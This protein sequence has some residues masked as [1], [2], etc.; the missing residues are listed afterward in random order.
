MVAA[1]T[2]NEQAVLDFFETLSS[3]DLAVLASQLHEDMSWEP[4]VRDIPGA[5]LHQGRDKV[6][7]EFLAPVRGA[8]RPG[9]PKVSVDAMVS[10]GD[11]V[12][13][14]T[15]ATG[16]KADDGRPYSN[17]Y[18]WAFE[19]RDG[20]ILRVRE[21]MDSLYVARFWGMVPDGPGA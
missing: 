1:K 20:K 6:I 13:A 16:E 5:G 4:M 11:R 8:F 17:R 14:E 19:F 10:D 21:Y 7:N 12:M 18:A 9:D 3:G 15:S 2:A